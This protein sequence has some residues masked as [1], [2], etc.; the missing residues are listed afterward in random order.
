MTRRG[1]LTRVAFALAAAVVVNLALVFSTR[2]HDYVIVTLI[3]F[4][5]VALIEAVAGS[6]SAAPP[7]LWG[8]QQPASEVPVPNEASLARYQRLLE[9]Q[10]VSRKHDDG[11]QRQLLAL[12]ERSLEQKHGLSRETDPDDVLQRLEPIVGILMPPRRLTPT[13]VN[14]IIDKI[15]EL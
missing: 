12:A 6:M 5:L 4:C 15:E 13:E 14:R 2:H 1:L 8:T 10:R 9:R 3:V 7:V 11:L